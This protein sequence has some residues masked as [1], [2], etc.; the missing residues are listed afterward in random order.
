[1]KAIDVLKT[2]NNLFLD[3]H[4]PLRHVV[5][6]PSKNLD[7][8]VGDLIKDTLK[9]DA[10]LTPDAADAIGRCSSDYHKEQRLN[11]YNFCPRC[12]EQLRR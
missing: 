12:G 5:L 10:I 9:K 6:N 8:T 3:C 4:Y 2:I 11:G 7:Y 1:L